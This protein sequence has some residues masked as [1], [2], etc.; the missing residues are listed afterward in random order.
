M[1][2]TL[3]GWGM[4]ATKANTAIQSKANGTLEM[5]LVKREMLQRPIAPHMTS[6]HWSGHHFA[7]N[8]VVS[9]LE[10]GKGLS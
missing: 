2:L 5:L 9:K 10:N 6:N 4:G 7:V 3:L 8:P 1:S